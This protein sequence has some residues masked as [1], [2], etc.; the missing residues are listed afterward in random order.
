MREPA[1]WQDPDRLAVGKPAI[2]VPGMERIS[3]SPRLENP[4]LRLG[5]VLLGLVALGLGLAGFVVP[6][7]PGVPFLL[8]AA[9]A[10]SMSNERL[11]RWMM[12]NRWFGQMLR[13]YRA[14]LG[15]PRRIK[16]IAVST[17]VLV[18]S[19]SVGWALTGAIRFVVLA[20][21]VVGIAFILTRPT[22]ELVESSPA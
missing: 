9:W 20:L 8:V 12:T 18:L 7:L 13:D 4:L 19:I 10:F 22:R 3:S 14:G 2:T 1:A 15:I 16:V 6:G 17:V 21:G 11:Y 5:A